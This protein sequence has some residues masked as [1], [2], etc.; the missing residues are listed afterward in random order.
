MAFTETYREWLER[1]Q[2]ELEQADEA[3]DGELCKKI[4]DVAKAQA[5]IV[6]ALLGDLSPKNLAAVRTE[7]ER[8]VDYIQ[9][10]ER[11]SLK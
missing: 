1:K 3:L 9:Y 6:K 8:L 7:L 2:R 4:G 5:E 11:C 10:R